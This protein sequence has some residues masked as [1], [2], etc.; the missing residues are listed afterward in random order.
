[1]NAKKQSE[2]AK[3][4]GSHGSH[5]SFSWVTLVGQI[6]GSFSWVILVGHT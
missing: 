6:C 1:M 2:C 3:S 4:R 5:G